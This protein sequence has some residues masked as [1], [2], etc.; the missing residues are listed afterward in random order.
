MMFIYFFI[1]HRDLQPENHSEIHLHISPKECWISSRR[2]LVLFSKYLGDFCNASNKWFKLVFTRNLSS[3]LWTLFLHFP[4][5]QSTQKIWE[6]NHD[7]IVNYTISLVPCGCS[8]QNL[9][10]QFGSYSCTSGGTMA[11]PANKTSK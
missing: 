8:N 11:N 10:A 3:P 9:Q 4:R 2:L 6:H 7:H 5:L 1:K